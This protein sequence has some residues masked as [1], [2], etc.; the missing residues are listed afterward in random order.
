MCS[1]GKRENAF[2]HFQYNN[3]RTLSCDDEENPCR[4]EGVE[5]LI[6]MANNKWLEYISGS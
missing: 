5:M 4:I 6:I 1:V 2:T 3:Y